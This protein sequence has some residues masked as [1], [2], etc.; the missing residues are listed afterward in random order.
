MSEES[1]SSLEPPMAGPPTD[2]PPTVEPPIGAPPPAPEHPFTLRRAAP[3]PGQGAAASTA[4][5]DLGPAPPRPPEPVPDPLAALPIASSKVLSASFDVLTSASTDL[6]QGGLYIGAVLFLTVAPLVV[7]IFGIVAHGTPLDALLDGA[8]VFDLQTRAGETATESLSATLGLLVIVAFCGY[9]VV[10]I[11]GQAI[12]ILLLAGRI[13]G[14]PIPLDVAVVRSRRVFWRLFRAQILLG[15]LSLVVGLVVVYG[16][17]GGESESELV[18]LVSAAVGTVVLLPFAYYA[19]GIVIG[20]VN[21]RRALRRSMTL[22]RARKV[23]A[24]TVAVFAAVAQYLLVFG[25]G[26]GGDILARIV[27]PFDIGTGSGPV[28]IAVIGVLGLMFIVAI[29]SLVFLVT[30]IGV[31]PQVI[32]FL[33]LTRYTGGLD[34]ALA[35]DEIADRRSRTRRVATA[36]AT[37]PTPGVAPV[38]IS[39]GPVAG[40]STAIASPPSIDHVA[41]PIVAPVGLPPSYLAPAPPRP[42]QPVT[43]WDVEPPRRKFRWLP[44]PLRL[45]VLAAVA[46]MVVAL[47]QL[48]TTPVGPTTSLF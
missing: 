26:V 2:E 37:A 38:Q 15:I 44:I 7:V 46:C 29:G 14:R 36:P 42:P 22:V 20:D 39:M 17:F 5:A 3:P 47:V 45:A 1:P 18:S 32:A 9:F 12:A 13:A 41:T 35:A 10:S 19:T 24:L 34:G 25:A 8:T 33:A 27:A 6:R 11:E 48:A 40:L 31:A 4:G 30:A 21:V 16:V 28:A 23:L 43:Y